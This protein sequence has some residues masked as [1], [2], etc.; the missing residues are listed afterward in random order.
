MVAE[1]QADAGNAQVDFL[2]ADLSL[3]SEVRELAARIR[4]RY[5]RL[6]VLVNNA[7]TV[8]NRREVTAEGIEK[9]WALNHLGYFLLTHLLLDLLKASSPARI[10]NVASS[11]HRQGK[12]NFEDIQAEKK[13]RG[14]RRYG[15]TKLANVLFTKELARRLA[16]SGVT[17]NA[18]HPGLVPEN[19][20]IPE[21]W[22][23]RRV[24]LLLFSPWSKTSAQGAQTSL[25]LAT[26]PE[27]AGVTGSYFTDCQP[28]TPSKAALNATLAQ[29]VWDLSAQQT[30]VEAASVRS[31]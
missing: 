25:Y 15:D 6:D 18:A 30:G 9:T 22:G 5:S 24:A 27:V 12:I 21:S 10:V 17:A 26:S 28:R 13:Y 31:F 1:I 14:F 23:R 16:G 11:S 29:E 3:Q 7:G 2:R 19:F 4:S 8:Y 20:P